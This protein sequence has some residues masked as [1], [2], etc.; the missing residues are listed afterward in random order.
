MAPAR[1]V[2][3]HDPGASVVDPAPPAT[4]RQGVHTMHTS[5]THHTCEED[6]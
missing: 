4:Y 1:R 6:R 5:H 3:P 2:S